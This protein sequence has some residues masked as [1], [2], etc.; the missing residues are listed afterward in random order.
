MSNILTNLSRVSVAAVIFDCNPLYRHPLPV[1]GYTYG[2]H[3]VMAAVLSDTSCVISALLCI[4]WYLPYITRHNSIRSTSFESRY[5]SAKPIHELLIIEFPTGLLLLVVFLC[6]RT[7]STLGK[8][9]KCVICK[10][11]FSQVKYLGLRMVYMLYEG[12]NNL[13]TPTTFATKIRQAL[14]CKP[15]MCWGYL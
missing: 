3:D 13:N 4:T 6:L 2:Q 15:V 14:C 8:E 10:L 12:I 5:C 7:A 1:I 11:T 9:R